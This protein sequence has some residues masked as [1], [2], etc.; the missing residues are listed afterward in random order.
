MIRTFHPLFL[1]SDTFFRSREML[2]S[3]FFCQNSRLLVGR[4]DLLQAS[5]PCQKQPWTNIIFLSDG[6]TISGRPGRSF[7]FFRN[8]YPILWTMDL[9]CI[10]G[11]VS[12]LPI[13]A[14]IQLRFSGSKTS[15]VIPM[16]PRLTEHKQCRQFARPL[17]AGPHCR[18]AWLFRFLYP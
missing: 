8:L 9:T 10:S 14:I 16:S 2:A 7:R 5:W 17:E 11:F 4:A 12:L 15:T 1:S 13:R 6:K 3:S 18:S